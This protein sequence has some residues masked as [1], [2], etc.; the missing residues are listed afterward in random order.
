[1]PAAVLADAPVRHLSQAAIEA[2]GQQSKK[3]LLTRSRA[4]AAIFLEY[5]RIE[6]QV[7]VWD[8]SIK[9][10]EVVRDVK[11]FERF[12]PAREFFETYFLN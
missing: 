9:K 10:V 4:K 12:M 8:L 6:K 3:K 5:I 1:M 11:I 7:R 2:P